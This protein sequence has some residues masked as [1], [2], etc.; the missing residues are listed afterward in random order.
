MLLMEAIDFC[1]ISHPCTT[2]PPTLKVH[3]GKIPRELSMKLG[4]AYSIIEGIPCSW[5]DDTVQELRV[6]HGQK[7]IVDLNIHLQISTLGDGWRR[8]VCNQ[9]SHQ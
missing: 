9:V 7:A 3:W 5:Y 4:S 6:S 2:P 8:T 1:W